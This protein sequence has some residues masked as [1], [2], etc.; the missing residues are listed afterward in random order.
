MRDYMWDMMDGDVARTLYSIGELAEDLR[1]TPRAIRFYEDKGLIAPQRV[2]SAR[3][4]DRRDRARVVLILR[5]KR[6]GFALREIRD[7]LDLYDADPDQTGQMRVLLNKTRG[8]IAELERQRDDIDVT[9]TELRDIEAS[10]Y[11]HL[12]AANAVD[13]V[14]RTQQPRRGR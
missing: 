3:V 14:P 9:L 7:W 13:G 6:L 4:Y 1:V 2:G 10:V 12:D 8:R 5:G 11:T